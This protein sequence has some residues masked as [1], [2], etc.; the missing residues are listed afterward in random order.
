MVAGLECLKIMQFQRNFFY[1][2][3]LKLS[4]KMIAKSMQVQN[5]IANS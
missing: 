2:K 3:G 1:F 5:S 4:H